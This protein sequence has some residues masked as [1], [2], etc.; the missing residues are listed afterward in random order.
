MVSSL[1]CIKLF[2]F[3]ELVQGKCPEQE[4]KRPREDLTGPFILVSVVETLFTLLTP[5]LSQK[6]KPR[7]NR[8]TDMRRS[9]E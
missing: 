5:G 7:E 1:L 6:S 9:T 3:S 4:I 2:Y 8:L